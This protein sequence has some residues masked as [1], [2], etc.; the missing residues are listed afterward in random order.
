MKSLVTKEAFASGRRS[1]SWK[2]PGV[3]AIFMIILLSGCYK[4]P[5]YGSDGRPGKAY[6]SAT[7]IDDEPEY[8]DVGTSAL[9]YHFNWGQFYRAY[10]GFFHLYF[11]GE[12]WMG[13]R[14]AFYAWEIDYEIWREPGEPGGKFYHGRNGADTYFTLECSPFGPMVYEDLKS[15]KTREGI[16]ILSETEEEIT[17]LQEKNG[18]GLRATYRKAEPKKTE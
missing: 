15:G 17:I 5:W 3:L 8:I 2:I 13:N 9:P 18:F 4:E 6:L 14:W 12:V 16:E 1:M 7:W 10:P 11:E